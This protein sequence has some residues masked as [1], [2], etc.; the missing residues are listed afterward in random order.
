[1]MTEDHNRP[2]RL[3]LEGT[4]T[5]QF[6]PIVCAR[7]TGHSCD[8]PRSKLEFPVLGVKTGEPSDPLMAVAGGPGDRGGGHSLGPAPWCALGITTADRAAAA[9]KIRD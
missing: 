5:C 8:A 2:E 3:G 1:M 4:V 6:Q 7:Q 9:R